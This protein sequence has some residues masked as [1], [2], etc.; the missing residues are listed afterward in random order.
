MSL[1]ISRDIKRDTVHISSVKSDTRRI[2]KELE[3]L[4][5]QLPKEKYRDQRTDRLRA[6]LDDMT[7]Y[8]G[9]V[10][11]ASDDEK[12]DDD[13]EEARSS[14]GEN[15]DDNEDEYDSAYSGG[16]SVTD[17]LKVHAPGEGPSPQRLCPKRSSSAPTLHNTVLQTSHEPTKSVV[18][19]IRLRPD[20][21]LPKEPA[22]QFTQIVR[23]LPKGLGTKRVGSHVHGTSREPTF[24]S[25][26]LRVV[27]RFHC[28]IWLWKG[29]WYIRDTKSL[30]GTFLNGIRLSKQGLG[31]SFHELNDGDYLKLAKTNDSRHTEAQRVKIRITLGEERQPS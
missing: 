11:G 6:T 29:K 3:Q 14:D 20:M 1:G 12:N 28:E 27:S 25:F 7:D 9:S 10:V 31:S 22:L 13:E 24:I 30:G 26:R 8:A 18:H 23:Y 16:E 19:F 5:S 15:D 21:R 4:R 17:S 2:L